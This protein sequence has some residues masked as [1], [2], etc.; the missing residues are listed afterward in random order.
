[1][2]IVAGVMWV[3]GWGGGVVVIGS[4]YIPICQVLAIVA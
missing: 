3:G 2:I 1:M 4:R